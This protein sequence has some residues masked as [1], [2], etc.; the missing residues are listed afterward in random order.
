TE[1]SQAAGGLALRPGLSVPLTV[2]GLNIGVLPFGS[3]VRGRQY[4]PGD[5][6]SAQAR[7]G[8]ASPAIEN[9]RLYRD[10]QEAVRA[11]DEF[12]SIASHELKTPLT[13]LQLQVQGLLR[14]IQAAALDPTLDIVAP[15]L[16]TAERQVDRLTDL[17]N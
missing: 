8:R 12:L 14:K 5:V 13:T 2:R 7:G 4:G 15:R 9:A 16:L 17:I 1:H 11:R 3:W 10:A 6:A